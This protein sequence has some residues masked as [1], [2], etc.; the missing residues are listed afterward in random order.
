MEACPDIPSALDQA[1]ILAGPEG[2]VVVTGSIYIVGEAMHAL[3]VN[4]SM[5]DGPQRR[6]Q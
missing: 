4:P 6:G 3:G 2:L 5:S 1:Q